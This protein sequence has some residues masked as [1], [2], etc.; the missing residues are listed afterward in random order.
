MT[1]IKKGISG[2]KG[3]YMNAVEETKR[4]R[5]VLW[6]GTIPLARHALQHPNCLLKL[7]TS[8]LYFKPELFTGFG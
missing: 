3:K 7:R 5:L 1:W 4:M 2:K 8:I 6:P